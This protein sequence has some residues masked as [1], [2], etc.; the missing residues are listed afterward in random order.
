[1]VPETV[2][3]KPHYDTDYRIAIYWWG[4]RTAARA[5]AVAAW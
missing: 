2:K 5:G 1:M 3:K 4:R